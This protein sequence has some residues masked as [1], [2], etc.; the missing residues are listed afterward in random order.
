MRTKKTAVALGLAMLMLLGSGMNTQ[1]YY[2]EKTENNTYIY[3]AEGFA[4]PTPDAYEFSGAIDMRSL[5]GY[6][7]TNLID[8]CVKEN[9]ELFLLEATLGVIFTF[10]EELQYTGCLSEF[11]TEDGTV[12]TLNK[13]EGIF[14]S[15]KDV[16][17]IADTGNERV[18]ICDRQ[19]RVSQIVEKPDNLLGTSLSSFLPIRAVAD[20]AGRISVVAR[21]INS[22]IMQFTK[23]GVF[24]GYTGAPSVSVDAFDKLLRK[25]YT[26]EQ[27]AT[28]TTYVPTEY[29]NI[30]IDGNNFIW[31]TISALSMADLAGTVSAR[32]LSGRVTPIKKLNM[33][34][35]DVLVR[36]GDFAPIGD[37]QWLDSPSKITDVGIG[38]NQVYSMLDSSKGRI[39]TYNAS[40]IL[41]Y[42]F[43]G[44]G[45]A[46]GDTQTPIA[47]DY[48]G[49]R[50]LL[51]D[52]GLCSV[53]TYE[54][55]IY[56]R[57]LI[58]AEGEYLAGNYD[59][60]NENWKQV[61]ELNSNFAYPYIG[62]GNA[63]YNS[64]N[65]REAMD[66]YQYA[67]DPDQ[68]SNA[69]EK[70]RKNAVSEIFPLI[71][72]VVIAGAVIFVGRGVYKKARKYINGELM[73]YG[74]EDEE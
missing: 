69:K 65:Y 57:L 1:A 38:P 49:D 47:I 28:M 73:T 48:S 25:F 18:L 8:M 41:L 50:I 33:M 61:T 42:I 63:E 16:M 32:D 22:G 15:E 72:T 53:L 43:G 29:N 10:D 54:P 67:D 27:R 6:T 35:S 31:G 9:G 58:D 36:K 66:Y 30:K 59:Q 12:L 34:G 70:L 14:V 26:D 55:T 24:T 5:E 71:A 2:S 13:P 3:D 51:L 37:I 44:K 52:S 40:G 62:L 19:G 21:N 68:Y 39:F 45:T 64:G 60:A 4:V 20:S 11:Y 74:R 7:V 17:Y 23:E 46:K 56:G